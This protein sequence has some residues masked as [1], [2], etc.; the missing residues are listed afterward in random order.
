MLRCSGLP[1][2][3]GAPYPDDGAARGHGYIF[4][5]P[6]ERAWEQ[7][8]FSTTQADYSQGTSRSKKRSTA[9]LKPAGLS[10]ATSASKTITPDAAISETSWTE[11]RSLPTGT[12]SFDELFMSMFRHTGITAFKVRLRI[13]HGTF[14]WSGGQYL[15]GISEFLVNP[16][17]YKTT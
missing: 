16:T 11:N 15:P 7:V 12:K 10:T 2:V 14:V 9:I 17:R 13:S 4:N 3:F 6:E 1:P 5:V 8:T